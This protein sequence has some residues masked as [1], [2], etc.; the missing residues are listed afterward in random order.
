MRQPR[1]RLRASRGSWSAVR[2]ERASALLSA[3]VRIAEVSYLLGYAEPSV[4][5]RAFRR[6]TGCAPEE[7]RRQDS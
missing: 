1:I 5:H 7:W 4:F 3:G 2:R 6:W